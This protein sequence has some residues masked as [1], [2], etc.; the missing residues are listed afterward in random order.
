MKS[1]ELSSPQPVRRRSWRRKLLF[2]T[3]A[4]LVFLVVVYFVVTSSAFFKGVILPRVGRAMGGEVTVADASLSPFS[5]VS[6]RQLKVKTTGAEPLLQAEEVR[7]RYG[8][9]AI[10]GGTL[11]VDEVTIASPVVQ[12]IE[13]ADGSSNL[14]P[15][16]KKETKSAPEPAPAP[17]KPPQFDM[18]NFALKNAT[19]RR[20]KHL[21]DGGSEVAELTG[22]NITLDQLKNGQPGKLTSAAVFKMARPT[23]DVLEARSTGSIEFTLGADLMPQT[24]KAKVDHEV[25]RAEGSLRELAGARAVFAGDIVP[26][27]VKELSQRFLKNDKVLGELKVTGPL[28]LSKKEGR[29]K[30][31]LARMDR[32]ALNLLGAPFGID[33][34]STTLDS[35]TDVSVA[36]GGS[37]IAATTRFNAARFSVTQQ[38]KTTPPLDL[39]LACNVTVNTTSQSAQVQTLTL[40]GRQSQKP[41][42][43]GGLGKPMTLAW[44]KNATAIENS[45]FNLAVTDFDLAAWKP[46]LGDSVSAGMLSLQLDLLSEQGGKQLKLGVTSR[47]AGLAAQLG[48]KP[49]TQ[50]AMMLK[51]N[52]HVSDFTK[53]SVSDYRLDLTQQGQPALT[54]A[55][56]GGYDGAAFKLQTQVEAVLARLTGSGPATPLKAGVKLDGSFANQVLDLRQMQLALAPTPRAP[57]NELTAAGRIDLSS[58]AATQGRM[59]IKSDMLDLTQLY[60]AFT[61]EK[62]RATA[63]AK[64]PTTPGPASTGDAEPEPITLPLNLTAEANLGQVYLREMSLQNCQ[65][66]VKVEG[67]KVALDPCRLAMNGAPVNASM[68]LDLGVKG[69]TYTLSAQ[70]DKVPLEPIANTFSPESRGQY[71][72]LILANAQIKGAGVT[73]ASLQKNLSG[74]AGF[75]FTN[76]N[77]QLM[78]PKTRRLIVPIATLLRIEAITKSPVNWLDART[79]LGNGNINLSRFAVQSGAFEASS[80][81]VIPIAKVLTNSPLNLPVEFALRRPLAESANLLPPNTPPDAQYVMLPRF[82]T[83]KGTLGE[84]KSDLNELALGGVLL[85]SGV[86]VAEKL[87]VNVGGKTGGAIESVGNLLTGQKPAVGNR[88]STNAAPRLNPLDLFR[89]K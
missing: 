32:Q 27:E 1:V 20:V 33:F 57:T 73:G 63:P 76:A 51:L 30:F 28:D 71:Q 22:V 87:G 81:G 37:V 67:S 65:V 13:Q 41:L 72:G 46:F 53:V 15:L 82:V 26:G 75:S 19:I 49:L 64:T 50:A 88:T 23:N 58:A 21:K 89:K 66:T 39:Q 17:S 47:I 48:E 60:D 12:I 84:P 70:L 11:K 54:L 44:G 9:F 42:L 3:G 52:A 29:L 31:E 40:D 14:D 18:R 38:G 16:L 59:T 85:K 62:R 83:L 55:G 86:G 7:L 77:L 24:L 61:P 56:S 34:G 78:G 35:I 69:F 6:L 45:T 2:I 5:Q 79:E 8:L 4:L 68:Q 80:Q 10:F 43:R 36:Q 74:Q 25:T